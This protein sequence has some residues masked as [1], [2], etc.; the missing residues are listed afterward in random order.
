LIT[1]KKRRFRSD[2]AVIYVV[3]EPDAAEAIKVLKAAG[4]GHEADL[5]DVGRVTENLLNAL[6]LKPGEFART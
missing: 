1:V 3:A 5:E 6:A 4:L 2:E